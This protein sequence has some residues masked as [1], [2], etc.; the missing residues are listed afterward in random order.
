MLLSMTGFG[1]SC[2]ESGRMNVSCSAKSVNNRFLK[3]SVRVP[4]G[5][6]ALEPRVESFVRERLRRGA[7]QVNLRIRIQSESGELRL[8]ADALDV[9][10]RQLSALALEWEMPDS[11]DL[12]MLLTLPGV[13]DEKGS[14]DGTLDSMSTDEL[15]SVCREVL[16]QA[17]A[18]LQEMR[19]DEGAAMEKDLRENLEI[20]RG[21]I[22]RIRERSPLVVADYRE[23][24]LERVR[25]ALADHDVELDASHIIRE[26]AIFADRC[27]IS[28][29]IVRFESHLE[30]FEATLELTEAAGRK[31]EFVSQEMGR[32]ANTI[33]SKSNDVEIAAEVV[34]IK[35]SLER[36]REMIQNVE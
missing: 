3:L 28:E 20:L 5:C 31:L 27:D 21:A 30:Q 15:W 33:G 35:S 1:E 29:E 19:V 26:I 32:E 23:R 24:M 2:G 8:N 13:V 17:L 16:D 11:I 22:A 9:Y 34:T 7:V 25:T 6:A 4:E 14:T 18:S 12:G 10:R 36:I